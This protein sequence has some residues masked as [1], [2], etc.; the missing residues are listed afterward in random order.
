M[1]EMVLLLGPLGCTIAHGG[2]YMCSHPVRRVNKYPGTCPWQKINCRGTR[3]RWKDR[4]KA[5]SLFF[6]LSLY[7]PSNRLPSV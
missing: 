4:I 7:S 2:R 3:N 6:S 5:L 1:L